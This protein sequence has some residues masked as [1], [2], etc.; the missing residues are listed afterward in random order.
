MTNDDQLASVIGHEVAHIT[1][2]HAMKRL[3][4]AYGAMAL[5]GA[6][7]ISGNNALAAG[8]DLTSS[9]LLFQNSREDEFEADRLGLAYMKAAGYDTSQVRVM[10]LK[11]SEYQ[12]KQAPR[13]L[14]Y[15]RTHPYL[16]QRMAKVDAVAKGGAEFRDYLNI[17]GEE[18]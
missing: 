12:N 16:P 1:A 8:I 5:T 18:R 7:I 13:P 17:T 9:S 6:A 15:W 2:K 10:L 3:Q 4:G 11:L 14:S